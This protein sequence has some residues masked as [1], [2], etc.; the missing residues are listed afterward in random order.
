MSSKLYHHLRKKDAGIK[1][2]P[3]TVKC[4]TAS[5]HDLDIIGQ[6][7]FSLKVGGFS[8]KW[9][10][11]VSRRLIGC[12]ILGVDFIKENRMVLD[13]GQGRFSFGFAPNR[14]FYFG[15]E[16]RVSR[17]TPQKLQ[18][19]KVQGFHCGKI[20][21]EQ[22]TQLE[23]LI[24]EYGDVL[25]DKLGRTSLLEYDIQVLDKTPVRSAPYRLSPPKMKYLK[26]HIEELLREGVIEPSCSHY[27]SP[28]FLVPKP[29]GEYRAV[30]DYRALNKR[31]AIES[32]PLPEIHAAFHWFSGAN[33]FTVLD[34]NKAYH[35]IPLSQRSRHLTA[36]CTDWNL[37]QFRSV[38]FGLATG[39]QVLTR[40]LDRVFE[41]LKF[42]CVY[43]YLD[44]VVIYSPDFESHLEHIRVVLGR[45]RKAGLTVRLSK[46]VFATQEI[47][48]LGHLVSPSGVRIDPERTRAIREFPIPR[49]VK[50]LSRFIGMI[51]YYH[52]FIP[53][54]ADIAFPLN[55]LRKKGVKYFWNTP[56]QKAFD[57]LKEAISKPP[58]L[59]MADF[60]QR[61]ILQTDASGQ[62]LGAVLSQE[63]A[64]V[65][66]PIAYASR[67][68]TAQERKASSTYEL[69]CL[70]I[71]FGT[72]KFRKYIEHQ[73][74]TLET[75]NQALSWLLAHPRQ[76]G[77]IGRWV[78]KISSL[79][80]EVRHI[81]GA[82]N[83]VADALS[84][85]HETQLN[86]Q[87]N[88]EQCQFALTEFPLAFQ[89]LSQLQQQD[90][91]LG[92]IRDRLEKG[93]DVQHY[94]LRGG[95]LFWA[96]RDR[97]RIKV[98]VPESAKQMV[99]AYFHDSPMG[100]H[101]GISKTLSKIRQHFQWRNMYSDIRA[102]VRECCTCGMSKPAQNTRLGLLAS[103]VAQ[104][105]MEKIFIDHVG[106][107]PRSKSGNTVILVCV[108][109][110]TKFVWMIPLRE[111]TTKATIKA[112][113]TNIFSSFSVP[114]IIVSDN[115]QCFVAREFKRFCFDLGIKH[116]TTAP[117][118]PQPSHAERFN[119]NLRAALIAYHSNSQDTWDQFLPWLQI[120]FNSAMHE[121]IKAP[122]FEIMFPFRN[123]SPLL[124]RWK[125][126]E[127]LP[128]KVDKKTLQKRWTEARKAL[129]QSHDKV[130]RQYN[131]GRVPQPFRVGDLVFYKNHPVS[132]AGQGIS[133]K[134]LPRYKGPFKIEAFLT[135]VTARLVDPTSGE[136]VTRSHVTLLKPA[137]ARKD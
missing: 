42:D 110:F 66:R 79:K 64:G 8:W 15:G 45:L 114:E 61:F 57:I 50:A 107:F 65:R 53:H 136:F 60:S 102:K 119:R 131:R 34:L 2:I 39:A 115:A 124:S 3:A 35:Q 51:N 32:V 90:P 20:S 91:E 93:E 47:S 77:K 36:F 10:F 122:P 30:V 89:E 59:K 62:A 33:Y 94:F 55:M 67:T 14:Y 133:A 86:D 98:V 76:L 137:T 129:R 54:F 69:E 24:K 37:Y 49:D 25:S 113:K 112:L 63:D 101:L 16:E 85:M 7:K 116:V 41:G 52:K 29:D 135:P 21:G 118:H 106:K 96:H 28:M 130:E 19:S 27:A 83:C 4:V 87:S 95:T 84:R 73:E 134:L 132:H 6:T 109:A 78:V 92:E 48:F 121:A 13:L 99:F 12:P 88:P 128:D 1:I 56:Q 111:A 120:S 104:R 31:I 9:E 123:G 26:G 5:G 70:A 40:L 125:I 103:E 43:H 71:L 58:V 108:D 126:Q 11:L 17:C 100:G 72:D 38:P 18:A 117:Y 22:R 23:S 74:F 68:L 81:R 80:F 127:L 75:D 97:R 46:V 44:D 82:K 105:P